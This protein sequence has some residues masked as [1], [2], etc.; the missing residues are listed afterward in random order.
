MALIEFGTKALSVIDGGRLQSAVD[1][2]IA[3]CVEDCKDR[4]NLDTARKVAIEIIITPYADET[5]DVVSMNLDYQVKPTLPPMKRE[6]LSL[7]VQKNGRLVFNEH[8]PRA[9]DQTTVFDN[10]RSDD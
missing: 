4:P 7:G 1:K 6:G 10:E 9:V 3:R 5:G 2:S 8:S